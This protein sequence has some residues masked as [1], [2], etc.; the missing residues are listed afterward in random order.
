MYTI[1]INK[2]HC[3]VLSKALDIY[4]STLRGELKRIPLLYAEN[5]NTYLNLGL[6]D[7][8]IFDD[9]IKKIRND[10][11]I[12]ESEHFQRY[13][14]LIQLN[15]HGIN[16]TNVKKRL[17]D[18][19]LIF[20]NNKLDNIDLKLN[21]DELIIIQI[22]CELYW[23]IQVANINYISSIESLS[24]NTNEKFKADINY[25]ADIIKSFA[26]DSGSDIISPAINRKAKWCYD[27]ANTIDCF[28]KGKEHRLVG[29]L[30]RLIIK[31]YG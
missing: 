9:F 22:A 26:A 16:L 25:I 2:C 13:I 19:C 21:T 20:S 11:F 29:T 31:K 23:N 17:I 18:T 28:L 4:K 1:T 6:V 24:K 30:N 7:E 8:S 5:K 15:K 10:F 14:N 3:R 12:I 27:I